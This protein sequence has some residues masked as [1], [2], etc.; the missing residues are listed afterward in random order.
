MNI[1]ELDSLVR[2][3]QNSN[4]S[5]VTLKQGDK[6]VTIKK[7]H[8]SLETSV[9]D[10]EVDEVFETQ[11]HDRLEP[12]SSQQSEEL[13]EVTAPYVGLFKH[14]KPIIGLG[15][16]VSEGQTL[17]SIQSMDILNEVTAGIS[18]TI[19]DLLVDDNQPVEYGQVLYRIKA[20]K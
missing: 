7:S 5:E 13:V 11:I 2:L 8:H 3:V 10:Y 14:I 19:E 1:D 20:D 16:K 18:G 15:A 4:I 17:C 12:K 9:S 6:R